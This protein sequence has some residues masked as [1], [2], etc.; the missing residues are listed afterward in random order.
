MCL[1]LIAWKVHPDFPLVLAANR[2]EFYDRPSAPAAFW[3]DHPEVLA[4]RDLTA[5]GTWLGVTRRGRFAALT[6]YRDPAQAAPERPSRGALVAGFLTGAAEPAAYLAATQEY[7]ARCN[8]YN[9]LVGDRQ[10]LW[11]ASNVSGDV[12]S[13]APGIYGLSNQLLD[14]AWPKVDAA[15]SA[16]AVALAQ[17]P[18]ERPLAELL[19]DPCIH[20]DER[21]PRTG[22]PLEW[23]RALSAAFIR[24]PGYGTRASTVVKIGRDRLSFDEQTWL[25]NGCTD[26]R[27]ERRRYALPVQV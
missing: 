3:S 1:I 5:G 17:L 14:S 9:L 2:D 16:L 26:G 8:G 27:G 4:G 13:L 21:L 6:N 10:S 19:A 15:K 20:P 24:A 7:G 12:R 18:G 23:E 22:V 11:W 25:D